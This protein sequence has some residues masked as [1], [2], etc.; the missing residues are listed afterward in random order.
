MILIMITSLMAEQ[1][2]MDGQ[3]NITEVLSFIKT[4][5][6]VIIHQQIQ[7]IGED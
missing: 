1:Y 2:K 3:G 7:W 4:F 6:T 5:S